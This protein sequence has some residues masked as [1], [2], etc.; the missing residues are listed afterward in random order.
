MNEIY[1]RRKLEEFLLEDLGHLTVDPGKSPQ[2]VE[3]FIV[4]EDDGVFCGERIIAL[5]FNLLSPVGIKPA[6][7]ISKHDGEDFVK[8]DQIV[9]LNVNAE[10][11]RHGI[12][13]VLNLLG[14][15]IAIATYTRRLVKEVK[16]YPVKL[17][18]T[19]KTTPGLR[20]FEKYAVRV[21][22]GRNNRFGR[23]DGIL[24]KKEDVK[25]D[26]GIRRAIDKAF[27]EKSH[28][29]EIEIE[30]ETLEELEEVLRDGRVRCILLDNMKTEDLKKAVER[31]GRTHVLQ[32]SGID[33]RSVREIAETGVSYISVSS[34]ILDAPRVNIKIVIF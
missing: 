18:D 27:E 19:R 20:A 26:G 34:L 12:R 25:I 6:I 15:M 28:L 13:T 17:L 11:L 21:G 23:F 4:A 24:I 2:Y 22:D 7:V 29:E 32:A 10:I 16:G 1:L 33:D 8:G 5:A 14:H 31:C 3:A 30:V 9:Y